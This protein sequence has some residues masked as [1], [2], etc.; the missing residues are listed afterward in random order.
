MSKRTSLMLLLAVSLLI[1]G[2]AG[3]RPLITPGMLQQGV[4]SAVAYGVHKYPGARPFVSAA[5]PIICSA[6]EGTNLAPAEVVAALEDANV[7]RTPESVFI[8]NS[9]L[10]LYEGIYNAFGADAVDNSEQ[11]RSYLHATCLGIGLGIGEGVPTDIM[12]SPQRAN[13]PQVKWP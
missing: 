1:C 6:S 9:A 13:W 2:C 3:T 10:L 12:A 8:V 7:L 5:Q 11:L 4:G